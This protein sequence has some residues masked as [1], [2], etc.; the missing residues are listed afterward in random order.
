MTPIEVV[1]LTVLILVLF[2]GLFSILFGFPGTIVILLAGVVYSLLTGFDR[3]GL[4]ILLLLAG[5][6]LSAELLEF[7]LGVRGAAR[8]GASKKSIGA[9][10]IGAAAGAVLMTPFLF[11]L[12]TLIGAFLGGFLGTFIVEIMRRKELKPAMRA[13]YGAVAGRIAGIFVKGCF[14]F[15][16]IVIILSAVYS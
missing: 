13:S 9:S 6:S 10:L 8:F 11:G 2:L 15:A 16:M 4:K 1:G 3:I 12:G 7:Y 5:I 14:A